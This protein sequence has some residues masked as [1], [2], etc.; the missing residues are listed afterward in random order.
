[1]AEVYVTLLTWS[2][3]CIVGVKAM[4]DQH[5]ILMDTMNEL[6]HILVRGKD[7]RRICEQLEQL[8]VFT[9]MHFE[10]EELLLEMHSFPGL[11]EHRDAH[12]HLLVQIQAKLEYARHCDDVALQPLLHFFRNWY[13][14][15][16]DGL[17]QQYGPWLNARGVY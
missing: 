11:L 12:R 10:N 3:E 15:H 14:D 1:M 9:Q 8:I 2:H 7:R 17:D 13:R 6:R 5:G 16:I 4:D